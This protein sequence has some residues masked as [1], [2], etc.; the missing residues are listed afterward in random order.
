MLGQ[1]S[2]SWVRTCHGGRRSLIQELFEP[3][4]LRAAGEQWF[5]EQWAPVS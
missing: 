3:G 2:G 5:L 4:N 1:S